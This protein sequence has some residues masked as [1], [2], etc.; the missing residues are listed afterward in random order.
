[1]KFKGPSCQVGLFHEMS[2]I[3][4]YFKG[5]AVWRVAEGSMP[6]DGVYLDAVARGK[7]AEGVSSQAAEFGA[8][9]GRPSHQTLHLRIGDALQQR[10]RHALTSINKNTFKGRSFQATRNHEE[11]KKKETPQPPFSFSCSNNIADP[12]TSDVA[13]RTNKQDNQVIPSQHQQTIER[14]LEQ[15]WKKKEYNGE[16]H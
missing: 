16:N 15:G 2:K 12:T 10:R 3:P 8:V 6:S 14:G 11:R 7:G 4:P 13:W 5:I 9:G 1:M